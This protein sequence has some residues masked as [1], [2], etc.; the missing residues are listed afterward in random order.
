MSSYWR[1]IALSL[2]FALIV[3]PFGLLFG[4]LATEA[5][6]TVGAALGFSA[7]VIAGAAQLTALQLLMHDAPAFVAVMSAL[8]INL[9]MAMYSLSIAPHLKGTNVWQRAI[10]AYFLVD[11]T[12]AVA[13]S[14][15]EKSPDMPR[16][17]KLAFY[18]G[19]VT[20]VCLPWYPATVVGALIGD[21]LPVSL[22]LGFAMPLAFISMFAPLLR[23]LPHISAAFVAVVLALGFAWLPLNLGLMV[24]G[25][26]GMIT[27]AV[28]ETKLERAR[29]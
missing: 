21:A 18:A 6:L 9:R 4:V 10:A 12:Y 7:A 20:I 26:G 15:Y 5:G 19:S 14:E 28:V 24:A 25:L 29:A 16:R 1:G 13:H 8:A 27:G 2:P 11:A 23:S 22:D 3:I 17:N